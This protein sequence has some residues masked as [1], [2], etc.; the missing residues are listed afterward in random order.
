MS[1]TTA[2]RR[3]RDDDVA[4]EYVCLEAAIEIEAVC[5]RLLQERDRLQADETDAADSL[6]LMRTGLLRLKELAGVIIIANNDAGWP[7]DE[8][9]RTVFG[10][11]KPMDD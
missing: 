1:K 7:L 6:Y 10:R 11:S 5:A 9:E 2:P 3:V 8:L 4:A